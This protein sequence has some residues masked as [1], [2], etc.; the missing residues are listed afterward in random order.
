M[1]LLRKAYLPGLIL[2]LLTVISC[3]E[4]DS[5]VR[6]EA[7]AKSD[8][9]YGADALQ[10]MDYYLPAQR[11]TA[12]TKVMVLI[13]G[14][15]WSSGDKSEFKAY[16]DTMKKRFPDYA[17]FNINYRLASTAGNGFPVQENDVKAALDFI[18]K[19][20]SLYSISDKF[21]LLGASAGGHLALLQAYKYSTPLRVKAVI[22]FFGPSDMAAMYSNPPSS[23]NPLLIAALV[24]GTPQSN[25]AAYFQSSPINFVL[26][27]SPPTLTLQG[28]RD[29]LV[30]PSQQVALHARLQSKGVANEYVLYPDENHG[31]LGANLSKSFDRIGVF[32]NTHVK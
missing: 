3:K 26:A 7:S 30:S 18:D 27:E 16:L 15:A 4:T 25:A 20:R 23:V 2:A 8:V 6:L 17:L 29:N 22:N 21:V 24:G 31:W 10:R 5:E 9:A 11:S 32:L 19:R 14:G 13:H 28:G 1:N 12:D